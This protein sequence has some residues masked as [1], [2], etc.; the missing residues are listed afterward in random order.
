M[1][2]AI[3]LKVVKE[4]NMYYFITKKVGGGFWT[5]VFVGMYLQKF[6]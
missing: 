4:A 3:G 5:K 6:A 2:S 1:T